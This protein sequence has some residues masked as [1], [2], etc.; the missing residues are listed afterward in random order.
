MAR[1]NLDIK[2]YLKVYSLYGKKETSPLPQPPQILLKE[3]RYSNIC[4]N[5]RG[6]PMK[7]RQRSKKCKNIHINYICHKLLPMAK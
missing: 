7:Y 2:T 1:Y 5:T 4:E 3:N 6:K